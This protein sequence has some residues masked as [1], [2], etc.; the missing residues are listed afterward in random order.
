[1]NTS[2]QLFVGTVIVGTFDF[3]KACELLAEHADKGS[4]AMKAY[5]DSHLVFDTDYDHE[6]TA[7]EI[8]ERMSSNIADA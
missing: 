4:R 2:I 7:D 6:R 1:M 5:C 8:S 3:N